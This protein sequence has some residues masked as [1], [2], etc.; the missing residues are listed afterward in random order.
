MVHHDDLKNKHAHIAEQIAALAANERIVAR[1]GGRSVN[2]LGLEIVFQRARLALVEECLGLDEAAIQLKIDALVDALGPDALAV[3]GRGVMTGLPDAIV[4][5]IAFLEICQ[6][7]L[8]QHPF[9]IVRAERA[10]LAD[11]AARVADEEAEARAQAV[12]DGE[13]RDAQ[14]VSAQAAR[15]AEDSATAEPAAGGD[16]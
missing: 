4:Q 3:A 16:A 6:V 9:Q 2:D 8:G 1:V 5:Q 13:A 15:G 7:A 12:R 10:A 11:A 14:A